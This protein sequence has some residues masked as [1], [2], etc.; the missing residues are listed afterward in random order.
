MTTPRQYMGPGGRVLRSGNSARKAMSEEFVRDAMLPGERR[1]EK[2][3]AA[4]RRSRIS[5]R[6][7]VFIRGNKRNSKT[8]SGVASARSLQV[9]PTGEQKE[10]GDPAAAG[11]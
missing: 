1:S 4:E 11:P 6:K 5:N 8:T 3:E 10:P 9:A 7:P 2:P